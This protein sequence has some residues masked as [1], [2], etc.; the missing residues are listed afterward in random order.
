[1]YNEYGLAADQSAICDVVNAIRDLTGNLELMPAVFPDQLA[2]VARN[3]ADNVR[4]LTMMRWGFPNPVGQRP[5]TNIRNTWGTWWQPWLQNPAY[6]CL[7]PVTSFSAINTAKP[8]TAI[9][10]WCARDETRPLMCF[11]GIW[12]EWEGTRGGPNDQVTGKHLLFCFLTTG[13]TPSATFGD[14]SNTPVLLMDKDAREMWLNAP[15]DMALS[16][17]RPP[18]EGSLREVAEIGG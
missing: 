7:V 10:T 8:P 3:A 1:M 11:A 17:Q 18:P 15:L 13:T 16:L 2:P 12:R 9:K 6:R 14:P 4:E 5:V